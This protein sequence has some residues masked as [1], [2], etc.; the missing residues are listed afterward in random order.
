MKGISHKIVS[1]SSACIIL[2]VASIHH[3]INLFHGSFITARHDSGILIF[4]FAFAIS[5][6]LPDTLEFARFDPSGRRSSIIPHRTITHWWP[7]WAGLLGFT[8]YIHSSPIDYPLF[9]FN[10]VLMGI[11]A[12]ALTHLA[13]DAITISG[14]PILHPFS[15]RDAFK[16]KGWSKVSLFPCLKLRLIR[17][18]QKI[19]PIELIIDFAFMFSAAGM[20]YYALT[21]Y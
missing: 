19:D 14:I 4:A 20:V 7:I 15:C 12:S 10:Y 9:L 17:V 8:C 1:A 18:G 2:S 16:K 13:C 5:S 3:E 6:L 21:V 11:S